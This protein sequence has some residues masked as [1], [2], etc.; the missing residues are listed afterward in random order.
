MN[1]IIHCYYSADKRNCILK[2]II[3]LN[4]KV[5]HICD[6]YIG[7]IITGKVERTS[8]VVIFHIWIY[9]NSK[10]TIPLLSHFIWM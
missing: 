7:E 3:P 5:H 10:I 1:N 4:K 9:Q 8:A 6:V 2:M